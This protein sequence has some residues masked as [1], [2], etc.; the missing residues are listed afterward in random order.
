MKRSTEYYRHYRNRKQGKPSY[1]E[2]D[3]MKCL[4]CNESFVFL[5]AHVYQT[6][7]ILM[8][9]YKKQF[10]FDIKRGQ[11]KGQ[12][13]ELKNKTNRGI[14]NLKL[15]AKYRFVKGDKKAGKYERSQETLERLV[16]I[17]SLRR[18]KK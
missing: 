11:T 6:H 4:L 8:L 2:A 1:T 13:R 17:R 5:G 16:K 12:Y 14:K 10:G 15:G 18:K 3:M 7:K 9:D